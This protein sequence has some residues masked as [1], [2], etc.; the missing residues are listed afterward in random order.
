MRFDRPSAGE[1]H[2]GGGASGF[3]LVFELDGAV[4]VAPALG[5]ET[6]KPH[7]DGIVAAAI[8]DGIVAAA[9]PFQLYRIHDAL[10]YAQ[11]SVHD[12]FDERAMSPTD[13]SR[14]P[15]PAAIA[16]L[17]LSSDLCCFT[18]IVPHRRD[19]TMLQ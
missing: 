2:A 17:S 5:R 14:S 15:T 8:H 10:P 1:F 18:K 11:R 19:A 16:G 12:D 3:T 7:H 4:P 9:I 6:A 13:Q